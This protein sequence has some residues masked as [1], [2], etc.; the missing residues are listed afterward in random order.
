MKEFVGECSKCKKPVYCLEGF[1]NGIH[2][3]QSVL[4][5]FTCA[6]EQITPRLPEE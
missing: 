1:L 3:N 4:L 5:C 6:K 2:V